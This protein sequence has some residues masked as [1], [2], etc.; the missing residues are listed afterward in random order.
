MTRIGFCLGRPARWR[1]PTRI[2]ASV[3]S[4][5]LTSAGDAEP[6]WSPRGTPAPSTTTIHL[7]PLPRLVFP[8]PAPLFSLEQ[9]CRPETTRSTAIAG[10]RLTR[11]R[12]RARC[13]AKRPALPIRAAAASTSKDADI[14]P[15]NPANERRCGGST[16]S[17]PEHDGFRST[18][19]RPC[20]VWATQAFL[21]IV[22]FSGP[23]RLLERIWVGVIL[24]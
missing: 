24:G 19:D 13:S 22:L 14:S 4:A 15:A 9:N 10:V 20:V 16:E 6:R 8:N 17:L 12:T 1:R 18:G 21:T 23:Q 3:V 5:S 7:V 11:S 2:E